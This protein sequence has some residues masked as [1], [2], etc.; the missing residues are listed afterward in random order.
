MEKKAAKK[1][2]ELGYFVV[3]G[4]QAAANFKYLFFLLLEIRKKD[5][6]TFF[7]RWFK[8]LG[9]FLGKSNSKALCFPKGH[10]IVLCKYSLPL[11]LYWSSAAGLLSVARVLPWSFQGWWAAELVWSLLWAKAITYITAGLK[12][13][14][15]GYGIAWIKFS[16]PGLKLITLLACASAL[17]SS[18]MS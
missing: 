6:V 3:P 8:S 14:V 18:Q 7:Q 2:A 17:G 4:I 1:R 10:L 12:G 9:A 15:W 16:H 5:L 13:V 11:F